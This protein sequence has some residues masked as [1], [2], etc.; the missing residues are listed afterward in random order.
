MKN[1][2]KNILQKIWK[3]YLLYM[4]LETRA[5]LNGTNDMNRRVF[6]SITSTGYV[7][8]KNI[9]REVF[10]KICKSIGE[11]VQSSDVKVSGGDSYISSPL[12]V[13]FHT[14]NP[15]IPTVGWYC[16]CQDDA[17]GAILIV[18]GRNLIKSLSPESIRE[19][20]NMRVSLPNRDATY[21][22]LIAGNDEQIYYSP[23]RWGLFAKT[24]TR[25]QI[26]AIREFEKLV[27]DADALEIK[28]RSG[29]A[30]FINNK[31]MLHGRS[32]IPPDSNRHLIRNYMV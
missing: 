21:P 25:P 11:I 24:A 2:Q 4:N 18:D 10:E 29:D 28:L 1:M 7:V 12:E 22:A 31:I 27:S 23:V 9:S 26:R 6:S 30:L 17:N 16:I 15:K 3:S 14:D 32:S 5:L 13:P 20:G 8:V 19:L